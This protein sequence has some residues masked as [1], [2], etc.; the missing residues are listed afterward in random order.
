M[1]KK[2]TLKKAA[3]FTDLHWGKRGNSDIHNLDCY[4]FIQWFCDQVKCDPTI[5]H[6]MFLGDWNENRSALNIN[7]LNHSYRGA[8]M[9]DDLGLPVFFVVGNHDLYH[10][11]TREVH[12]VIPFNEFNNFTLIDEPTVI[13]TINSQILI[14]PYLFHSE[15]PDLT[16]YS[17]IP[18]WAGHFEFK[19]FQVTGYGTIMPTGPDHTDFANQKY[20]FSGH[21]HKRQANDNVIYIGNTFPMDFGDAG[22]DDRGMMTYDYE[23]D[24]L[25]FIDWVECPKY[26]KTSLTDIL[27]NTI[28][29]HHDSRVRCIVDVPISFEESTKLKQMFIDKYKLREFTLEESIDLQEALVDTDLDIELD[30]DAGLMDIDQLVEQM[31]LEINNDHLENQKLIDIYKNLTPKS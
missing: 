13:D 11:H 23:K 12:S 27:D 19:G 18:I 20:I 21:F 24:E 16:Q 9:I 5:D 15:Y 29:L 7:T 17:D 4:T 8:K 6:I 14:C 1:K 10:R 30:E 22:D 3:Y 31:L 2:K 28:T 25:L 26:T